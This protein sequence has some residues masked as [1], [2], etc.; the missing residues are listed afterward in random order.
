MNSLKLVQDEI[1]SSLRLVDQDSL[2][3]LIDA[4]A[5]RTRRWFVS[6]QGRSRLVASMAAMRLMH[7][8]ID[9]HLTGEV[10]ATSISE[11]D[12][13]LML[14]ASGETRVSVHLARRAADVGARVFAITTRK[15]SSL[16]AIAD[17]VVAVPAYNS[18]QFGGSLFEQASLILLDALIIDRTQDDPTPTRS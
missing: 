11:G 14:S 16:A 2:V 15:D 18:R 10:T 3:A 7:V 12:C 4:F 8:G 13:L 5:D 6:G 1:S 17:V 9:V